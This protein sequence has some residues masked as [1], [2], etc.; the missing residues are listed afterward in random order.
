MKIYQD[1][2]KET[3]WHAVS[4]YFIVVSYDEAFAIPDLNI[5]T[6]NE[7]LRRWERIKLGPPDA[8]LVQEKDNLYIVFNTVKGEKCIAEEIG[9]LSNNDILTLN[10]PLIL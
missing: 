3:N 1:K 5:H 6:L 8:T 7:F 2:S 9:E 10:L 4:G